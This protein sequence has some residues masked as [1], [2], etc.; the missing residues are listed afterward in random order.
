MNVYLILLVVLCN[1]ICLRASRI[2]V[3]LFAI[4][5]GAPQYLIGIMIGLYALFPALLAVY[6]GRLSDRK[7]PRLPMLGGS[8]GAVVGMLIPFA[9]PTMPALALS[10][11]VFGVAFI[12]YHVAVQN[13]LGTISSDTTR[14]RN[15]S[16][17][18]LMIAAGGFFGPLGAGISIDHF[19]HRATYLIV[20]LFAL[21]PL[22]L[23][24]TSRALREIHAPPQSGDGREGETRAT[25][26]LWQ[27]RPLR[28][29]LIGST[30]VLTATDLFEFYMPIYGH[31]IGLSAA[32][33]GLVLS[34]VGI[35][36]FTVRMLMPALARRT[37][38][39]RLLSYSLFL[40]AAA[41]MVFPLVKSML[42]LT[43]F[44][45]LLGLSLGCGQ[46][47][48]TILIYAH[49]PQGRTGE[50]LGL[51]LAINNAMHVVIPVA[52]GSIGSMFGVAPVFWANA[53]LM[54]GGGTLV[55][56]SGA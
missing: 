55:R 10:A 31:S 39:A 19:G 22:T 53:V 40:G 2:M 11:V 48:S 52:A 25:R 5:L 27:H 38:E 51:R 49:S 26:E 7:G 15:F 41:F 29:P 33:S 50:A 56:R 20:A 32:Q 13:M 28:G 18:S 24:A 16:N 44:G 1:V 14:T 6:A 4:E 23:L 46:P 36:A 54:T 8:A 47:L 43:L 35:A 34:M 42:V 21:L 37:G 9:M 17:Y 12:F 45:F 30:A 3:S